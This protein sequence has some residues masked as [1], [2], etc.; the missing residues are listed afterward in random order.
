QLIETR[1]EHGG[2]AVGQALRGMVGGDAPVVVDAGHDPR[3]MAE[4]RAAAE[5]VH[6]ARGFHLVADADLAHFALPFA[7]CASYAD[8]TLPHGTTVP[9]STFGPSNRSTSPSR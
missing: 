8:A 7:S 6:R 2:R 1:S 4:T 3:S 5:P 9:G